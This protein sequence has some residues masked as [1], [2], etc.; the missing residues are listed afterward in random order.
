MTLLGVF[1]AFPSIDA[2]VNATRDP[3]QLHAMFTHLPIALTM[4]G[5]VMALLLLISGGRSHGFRWA[6]VIVY[7]LA[8]VLAWVTMETGEKA[9]HALPAINQ[10]AHAV[11]HDHEELAHWL[12][13]ML[14]GAAVLLVLSAIPKTFARAVFLVLSVIAGLTAAAW[15]VMIAHLGGELVY[16]HGVG[17]PQTTNNLVSKQD[18]EPES[19]ETPHEHAHDHEQPADPPQATETPQASPD[20]TD[21]PAAA[22]RDASTTDSGGA[23]AQPAEPGHSDHDH[24]DP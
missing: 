3:Q 8:A 13:P 17:V 22:G 6:C 7:S 15:V 9:E 4:L 19:D 10:T 24:G 5:L 1:D 12:W 18:A 2:I 11:L 20:D 21:A 23:S 16:V 14:A